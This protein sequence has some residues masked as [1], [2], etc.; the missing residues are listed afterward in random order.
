MMVSVRSPT[1]LAARLGGEEFALILPDTRLEQAGAVC[2]RLREH[3]AAQQFGEEGQRF[4]VTLSL[5]VV[6]GR[7]QDIE[8]WLRHADEQLYR[9][10]AEGRDRLCS[11][12][13]AG[14]AR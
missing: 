11:L 14:D 1:D 6:E 4:Q 8:T 2:Q 10:K 7:G 13:L 12:K 3:V 5:G 9:A